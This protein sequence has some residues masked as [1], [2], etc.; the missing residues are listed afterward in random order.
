MQMKDTETHTENRK[1]RTAWRQDRMTFKRDRKGQLSTD[2]F[3]A[4]FR[5]NEDW[6]YTSE[7]QEMIYNKAH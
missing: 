7:R 3:A 6:G 2:L 4:H 5:E 1:N